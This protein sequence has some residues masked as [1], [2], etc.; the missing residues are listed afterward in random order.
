[1]AVEVGSLVIVLGRLLWFLTYSSTDASARFQAAVAHMSSPSELRFEE[2]TR[3][4]PDAW[5]PLCAR[6]ALGKLTLH[7]EWV[8][9]V[10][11]CVL[12]LS[13]LSELDLAD[14]DLIVF[15]L[16]G[17]KALT[18]A[19]LS[20]N[21]I[22]SLGELDACALGGPR[23]LE[24]LDLAHNRIDT[25]SSDL[26]HCTAL[27]FLDLSHN[28]LKTVTLEHGALPKLETL[29][30]EAT[31]LPEH[32]VQRLRRLLPGAKVVGP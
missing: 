17:A 15:S 9:Y 2:R 27:R 1:M 28:P 14:N 25:L 20:G 13:G 16:E 21:A 29:R 12:G 19:D 11:P 5:E 8:D 26:A 30:I 23:A 7:T 31:P 10:P 22:R 18:R 6:G 32:E 3:L 24:Y 4:R